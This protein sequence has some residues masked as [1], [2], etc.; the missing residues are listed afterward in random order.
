MKLNK[1]KCCLRQMQLNYLGHH[2]DGEGIWPDPSKISAITEL[3][4]PGNIPGLRRFLAMVHYLGR[5]LPNL[6]EVTKPLNDL[7]KSE[8]AWTWDA[9]Q[10]HAFHKVKQLISTAPNLAFYDVNKPIIVC[11][12]K[13][14][15]AGWCTTT[16]PCRGIE[17][18]SILLKNTH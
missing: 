14:L 4:Q 11:R 12:R 7:L 10:V 3:A 8:A 5:F 15:R 16:T 9:A 18:S 6:S 13:Q 1:E 17:T 2:I